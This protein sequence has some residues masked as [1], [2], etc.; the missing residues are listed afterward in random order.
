MRRHARAL[1]SGGAMLGGAALARGRIAAGRRPRFSGAWSSRDAAL[2]ALPPEERRGYDAPSVAEVSFAAMCAMEVWDYPVLHWLYRL[3]PG[4]PRLLDAGGH[5]GTKRIAFAPHLPLD[6]VAWTVLDTPAIAAAGRAARMAGRV[7]ADLAFCDRAEDTP[8]ADI[9]LASG[10][11]QYLDRPL[12]ELVE[13]L[14]VRPKHIVLNKVATRDGP[15]VVT[16]ERLDRVRVPYRIRDRA[17]WERELAALGYVLRDAWTVPALGHR[18]PTHP[19]LGLS[20]SRGYV[21]SDAS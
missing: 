3:L 2:A 17:A 16:H 19:W 7:P 20:T 12:T 14:P 15:E 6:G 21:L 4:A 8:G 11:L 9:L 18:I 10:L 1:V 5:M 13:A